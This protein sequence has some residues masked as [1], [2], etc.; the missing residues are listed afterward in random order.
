LHRAILRLTMVLLVHIH[1][2]SKPSRT[3]TPSCATS[4]WI[5]S[6][7]T[8]CQICLIDKSRKAV[9]P[10]LGVPADEVVFVPNVTTGV[11]TAQTAEGDVVVHFSTIYGACEK[12]LISISE[13]TPLTCESIL[14]V[15]LNLGRGSREAAEREGRKGE[16]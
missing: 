16:R 15:Y 8:T 6:S 11:N 12:T 10:L 5:L 1:Y 13:M 7:S 9:A 3:S 2:M 4:D 14:P